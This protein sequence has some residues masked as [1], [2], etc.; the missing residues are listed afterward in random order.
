MGMCDYGSIMGSHEHPVDLEKKK[1]A[2]GAT[3]CEMTDPRVSKMKCRKVDPS[4][5]TY[6]G[7]H[8]VDEKT[9][10][11]RSAHPHI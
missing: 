7:Q 11:V 1:K 4:W 9:T 8:V 3:V 10:K 2:A 5:H 6:F